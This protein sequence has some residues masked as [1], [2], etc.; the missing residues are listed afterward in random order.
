[1]A[2]ASGAALYVVGA[3]GMG[4]EAAWLAT[5]VD[6]SLEVALVVSPGF[7]PAT[8]TGYRVVVAE[9]GDLDPHVTRVVGVGDPATRRRL[10]SDYEASDDNTRSLIDPSA[11]LG[12]NVVVEPGAMICAGTILT[13]RVRI[14]RHTI[15]NIGSTV[16]HDARIGDF[17]T[18][19]PGVHL[20]G[21]VQ[22]E[23]GAFLGIGCSIVNGTAEAPLVVGRGSVVAAGAVVTESVPP[24]VMVAGTPARVRK[25]LS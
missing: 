24:G 7:V 23:D 6:P 21:H 11:I 16:S 3:G 15:V 14:G 19:S 20:A 5:R 22:V 17:V 9:A 8:D 4:R 13:T 25:R 18:I 1:M 2:S 12:E 10:C